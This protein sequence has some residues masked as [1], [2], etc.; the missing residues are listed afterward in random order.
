MADLEF[1]ANNFGS[2][3]KVGR[4]TSWWR[5]VLGRF[6]WQCYTQARN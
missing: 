3:L 4:V 2:P 5:Y 6:T 1:Q